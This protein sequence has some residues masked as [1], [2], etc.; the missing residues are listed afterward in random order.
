MLGGGGRNAVRGLPLDERGIY[1]GSFFDLLG[2]YPI[3]V[4]LLTV[5]LFVMHGAIYLFLKTEGG[6]QERLGRWMW[7]A[8]G[9]FLVLYLVVTLVTFLEHPGALA[10]FRNHPWT[11]AGVLLNVLALANIPRALFSGRYGQA[12]LSSAVTIACMVFLLAVTLYPNILTASNDPARSWTLVNA[13]SSPKTLSIGLLI[14][15]VGMPFVLAYTG[16]VYWTFR[17]KVRMEG[18]SY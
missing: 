16:I 11:L 7:H 12:F 3:L 18:E 8:W 1:I 17:G 6:V 2:L 5:A 15:G 14:A 9:V 13:A 4:G 10:N